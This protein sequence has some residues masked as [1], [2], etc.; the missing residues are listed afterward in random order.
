MKIFKYIGG[1]LGALLAI[2]ALMFIIFGMVFAFRW[3]TA[4]PRGKLEAR[5]TIQS[6]PFRIAAYDLFFNR[7]AQVQSDEATIRALQQELKTNPPASR[8]TQVHATIAALRSG[9]AE[10]INQYNADARKDYTIGQ[11]RASGLPYQ[12]FIE[13][14]VTTCVI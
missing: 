2:F 8:V 4:E 14:E 6:G 9:R 7:C 13:S 5:E 1:T 10:K 11:F 3:V 12:L